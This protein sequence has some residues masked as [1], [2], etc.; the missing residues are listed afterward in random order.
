MNATGKVYYQQDN[1]GS[2]KYTVNFHNGEDRHK[3]GSPFYS[4]R[5][6]KNKMLLKAFIR[7]LKAAGY[8]ESNNL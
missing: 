6:F 8:N 7:Q 2:C 5:I 4:I 3:D 1:I